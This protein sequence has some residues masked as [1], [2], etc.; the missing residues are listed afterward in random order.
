MLHIKYHDIAQYTENLR[1]VLCQFPA[2]KFRPII[3]GKAL[4]AVLENIRSV[5]ISN[6][7]G[8]NRLRSQHRINLLG[9]RLDTSLPRLSSPPQFEKS[10]HPA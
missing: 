4:S 2:L 5:E 7:Q 3:P 10:H 8:G 1:L 6:I 9:M